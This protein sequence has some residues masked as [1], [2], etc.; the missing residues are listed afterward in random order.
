MERIRP[1]PKND[2]VAAF[3]DAPEEEYTFLL[4]PIGVYALVSQI[5]R[6][7]GCSVGEVFQKALL[8]YVQAAETAGAKSVDRQPD[9]SEPDL[10]VKRKR[11]Q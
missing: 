4:V 8:A 7:Q 6:V 10:V 5:S 11:S 2:A 1:E 9:R 3:G